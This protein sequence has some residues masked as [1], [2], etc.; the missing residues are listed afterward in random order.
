MPGPQHMI[1]PHDAFESSHMGDT[2]VI[3]LLPVKKVKHSEVY[4]CLRSY[5]LKCGAYALSKF[6]PGIENDMHGKSL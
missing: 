5:S 6:S 4:I 2:I 3:F 1:Y